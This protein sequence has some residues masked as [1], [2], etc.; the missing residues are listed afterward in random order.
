[1][2]VVAAAALLLAAALPSGARQLQPFLPVGVVDDRPG[3]GRDGFDDLRT[4]RFTVVTTRE[5]LA[6]PVSGPRVIP[7]PPQGGAPRSPSATVA[8]AGIE[9]VRVRGDSSGAVVRR[10]AWMA[11]GRG[12]RGVVF[13]GWTT[14]L[15]NADALGA[16]AAFADVVTRNAAL[17]APLSASPRSVR[18]EPA[19]SDAFARFME[20]A[21]AVVLVAANLA[22]EARRIT[23]A[24]APETPEAIWQNMESGAAVNFV[25]GPEGPIY[26]R[27]FGPHDVVVLAIRKRYR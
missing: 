22:P 24:F 27:T 25:A 14:L 20:S 10:E 3:A 9:V 13:D 16:A 6:D 5:L 8:A 18:V 17:F 21:E 23:L 7:L 4:L 11:I 15:G 26:T 12:A 1:M 2:R 19:S